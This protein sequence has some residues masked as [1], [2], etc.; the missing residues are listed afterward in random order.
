M[1][2]PNDI[3]ERAARVYRTVN[4]PIL[5]PHVNASCELYSDP[6]SS[7]PLASLKIKNLPEIKLLDLIVALAALKIA[8]SAMRSIA[9]I[10]KN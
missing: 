10:F 4:K 1:K 8:V 2:I 5:R 9:D 7:E 6:I 3:C